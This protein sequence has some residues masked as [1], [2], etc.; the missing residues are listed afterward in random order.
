[1][2]LIDFLVPRWIVILTDEQK[3]NLIHLSF[4]EETKETE[5][6]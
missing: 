4:L 6:T 5:N 3:G 2:Q 1:M